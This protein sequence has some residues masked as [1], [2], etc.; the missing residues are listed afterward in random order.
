MPRNN[1][2]FRASALF[3]GSFHPFEIGD[4]VKA[5]SELM[6]A[7]AT[8]SREEAESYGDVYKV[9]PVGRTY[10]Q[11]SPEGTTHHESFSGFRVIGHG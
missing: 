11:K 9:E 2:D 8:D 10:S 6:P 4:I 3:H 1:A 7:Y 5:P